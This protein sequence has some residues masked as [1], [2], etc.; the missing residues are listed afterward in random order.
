MRPL[1][2]ALAA[3]AALAAAVDLPPPTHRVSLSSAGLTPTRVCR[4]HAAL[5]ARHGAPRH[6]PAGDA[7]ELTDFMD[8]QVYMGGWRAGGGGKRGREMPGRR[9][10]PIP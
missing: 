1:A 9:F 4:Q 7:V 3:C 5:A 8:A 2:F 10:C 6:G